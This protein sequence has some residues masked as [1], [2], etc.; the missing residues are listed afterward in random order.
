MDRWLKATN[1]FAGRMTAEEMVA[2]GIILPRD[3]KYEAR[4]KGEPAK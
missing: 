3:G 2:K 1:D 4:K